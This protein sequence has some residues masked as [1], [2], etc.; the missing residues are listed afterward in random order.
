MNEECCICLNAPIRTKI[1]PCGHAQFCIACTNQII[2][3]SDP[4][5]LCREDITH[6]QV[7]GVTKCAREFQIRAFAIDFAMNDDHT[8]VLERNEVISN[9]FGIY[10]LYV[11]GSL[12]LLNTAEYERN[13]LKSVIQDVQNN[14]TI[15]NEHAQQHVQGTLVFEMKCHNNKCKSSKE[16]P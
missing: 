6:Y 11:T 14:W 4:C 16:I 3:N 12:R 9:I 7:D 2:T 8:I 15:I 5:P 1:L 13:I 10:M